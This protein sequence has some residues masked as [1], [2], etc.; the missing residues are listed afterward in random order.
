MASLL[1]MDVCWVFL[2]NASGSGSLFSLLHFFITKASFVAMSVH[3][4]IFE[5]DTIFA[6]CESAQ[7]SG[8]RFLLSPATKHIGRVF[9][10][11]SSTIY[12]FALRIGCVVAVLVDCLGVLLSY[13]RVTFWKKLP[14]HVKDGSHGPVATVSDG[15]EVW[16]LGGCW[17]FS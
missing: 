8:F 5:A 4:T 13:L 10:A 7:S 6:L 12:R 15:W 1:P 16:G 14:V 17:S 3:S 9:L 11:E 2:W